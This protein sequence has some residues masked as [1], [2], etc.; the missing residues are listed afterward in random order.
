MT[1]M[2]SIV[3]QNGGVRLTKAPVPKPSA[4][5]VLVRSLAC[6]ICGSDLHITRHGNEVFDVYRSLGI[7]PS[8]MDNQSEVM[9]GHEFCAE[10]VEYG[11]N[12]TQSLAVGSR[13]TS[14]PL[15][16]SQNGAGIGVT[17]GVYGA[18]SEY[19][20]LDEALMIAVPEGVPS[21]AAALTEPLAV[22]LHAVNRSDI[23]VQDTALVVGCGPIGLAVISALKQR[24]V[25]RIVAVDIQQ[26]KLDLAKAFGATDFANPKL[27][28]EVAKGAEIADSGRLVIYECVGKYTLIDDF[29]RRSPA[30]ARIVVTGIHTAPA[31]INYAYATVKELDLRFSYYYQPHE[32]EQCLHAIA[33]HK[34][35]WQKMLTATVGI[36]GVEAA[37]D[38][39]LTPNDHIKVVIEP[40][41]TG[42]LQ[43]VV[44]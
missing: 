22:G 18:Y 14:V 28:D 11:A 38:T 32:F 9:L 33:E 39:L 16:M 3:M 1:M 19:F 26:Q 7:M 13:V 12:T 41:R 27:E 4:G 36:D 44:A 35:P 37:F 21:E 30:G 6:G 42:D 34:L 10:I 2:N 15:L 40:W 23:E 25:K 5:Q 24:G 29:M 8:E 43:V 20:L 17:P 31:T